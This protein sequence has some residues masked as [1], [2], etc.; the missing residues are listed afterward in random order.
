MK[1]EVYESVPVRVIAKQWNHKGD[2]PNVI[3]VVSVI[4]KY[5]CGS[6][7]EKFD[8][9]HGRIHTNTG[10]KTVCSGDWIV[11]E[12]DDFKVIKP[13]EFKKNYRGINE[14]S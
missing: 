1:G 12:G 14:N 5:R 8:Q 7:G 10:N 6:C 11:T 4:S 3:D 13:E 2:H 9:N